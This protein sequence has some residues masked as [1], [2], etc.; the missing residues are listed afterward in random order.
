[1]KKIILSTMAI[2]AIALTSCKK[3]PIDTTE[4]GSATINGTIRADI[5]QTDDVNGA[6][7]YDP[8]LN[9]EGVEGMQVRI[10]VWT[11]NYEQNPDMSYDYNQEVY[12]AT[13]DASGNF[14]FT[15]PATQQGFN[16]TMDFKDKHGI[17]RTLYSST[18]SSL[19][20]ESYVTKANE[21]VFIYDGASIDVVYDG[22]IVAENNST[23][24]H[25]MATIMG[26]ITIEHDN[27]LTPQVDTI[28]NTPITNAGPIVLTWDYAPYGAN[29]GTTITATI[30][31]NGQYKIDLP[32]ELAGGNNV[33]FWLGAENFQA[34]AIMSNF[35]GTADSTAQAIYELDAGSGDLFTYYNSMGDGDLIPQYDL[36][37]QVKS[38]LP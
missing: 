37:F 28:S 24:E 12:T 32:T 21:T 30:D 34:E 8:Y 14:S 1:M 27:G 15:I 17:T 10:E 6:G 3:D 11:G 16:V 22:N 4:L 18:G 23:N 9:P 19:T 35:L 36:N 31:A 38:Y 5:N 25:G 33:L 26:T 13:T 29:Y 2:A 20:E 7:L